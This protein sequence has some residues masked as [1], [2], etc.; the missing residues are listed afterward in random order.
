[1][2]TCSTGVAEVREELQNLLK[3]LGEPFFVYLETDALELTK[4]FLAARPGEFGVS[5]YDLRCCMALELL[6]LAV[7]TDMG[8][9]AESIILPDH[10]MAHAIDQVR[11]LDEPRVVE[12]LATGISS[13]A[14]DRAAGLSEFRSHLFAAGRVL[15]A[16][17]AKQFA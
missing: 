1:M 16:G 3:S 2:L 13:V 7:S 17:S 4:T 6:D 9:S 14:A 11:Q 8:D 15:A 5:D 10:L 12:A